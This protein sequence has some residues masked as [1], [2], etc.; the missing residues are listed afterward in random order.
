MNIKEIVKAWATAIN[1]DPAQIEM[2]TER[3]SVCLTCPERKEGL[4]NRKW[5]EFC[6]VC[7]CPLKAKVYSSKAASCPLNKW[8][9]VDNKYFK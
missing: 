5:S 2:A 4:S 8:D 1:P 7:G 3:Y 9:S 6:N